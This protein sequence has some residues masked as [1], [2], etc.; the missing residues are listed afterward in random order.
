MHGKGVGNSEWPGQAPAP[1]GSSVGFARVSVLGQDLDRQILALKEAGCIRVFVER[2]YTETS[3][4]TERDACL[5][6]LQP[7]DTLVV[8]SLDRL[9]RSLQDLVTVVAELNRRELRFRSLHESLDTTTPEGRLVFHVFT[10][11]AESMRELIVQ[12][13]REDSRPPAA[14]VSGLAGHP[15][16]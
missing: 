8:P 16:P 4:P 3:A 2:Q 6:C 12:G 5:D 15:R 1:I 13:T 9:G 11:L 10:A 14:T 7:G